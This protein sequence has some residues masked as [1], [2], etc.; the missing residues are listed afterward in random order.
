MYRPLNKHREANIFLT[1][2]FFLLLAAVY[3]GEVRIQ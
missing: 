1:P 2:D 3:F